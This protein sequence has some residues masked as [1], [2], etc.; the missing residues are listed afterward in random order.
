MRRKK[1]ATIANGTF[2]AV[3]FGHGRVLLCYNSIVTI[4][5]LT[6]G[7]KPKAE[8]TTLINSFTKRLPSHIKLNW[9][10]LKHGS[11]DPQKSVATESEN[12][13]RMIPNGS[14]VILLDETGQNLR[15]L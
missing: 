4:T 6:V 3:D 1:P 15:K 5:I 9:H 13:M 10:F 12:I 2:E 7:A 11:G 8:I 14:K